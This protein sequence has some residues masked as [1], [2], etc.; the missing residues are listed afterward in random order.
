MSWQPR[1]AIKNSSRLRYIEA[2]TAILF[3]APAICIIG[4]FIIYP[5]IRLFIMSVNETRFVGGQS[6]SIFIGL[7]QYRWI[8][9]DPLFFKS[10]W[11]SF[12]FPL[13]VTPIQTA[14]ALLM[15]ILLNTKI[16]GIGF[17]RTVY[18]IPVVMSF[19]MI[20][21]VWKNLLNTDF[22][23][24]NAILRYFGIAPKGF[25][26]TIALSKPSIAFVSIWKSWPWYMIIFT[27]A[28]HEIP[29]ELYESATIDGANAMQ[30]LLRITMPMLRNTFVF[31]IIISTMN[32]IKAFTPV[33][34]MTDGGPVDSSRT[35]VHY[36]WSTAFRMNNFGAATAMSVV[37]F[38]IMLIISLIQYRALQGGKGGSV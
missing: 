30:K 22:G 16:R 14:I 8:L 28:L 36:I 32:N 5:S 4:M 27:S 13:I 37:L 26:T 3:V 2:A 17:F 35:I 33:M 1:Q 9:K 25:L 31:V 38:V 34:V 11:N 15:A 24:V 18:F 23:A 7:F 6:D 19:V 20:A 29:E 12:Y 10:L 21:L